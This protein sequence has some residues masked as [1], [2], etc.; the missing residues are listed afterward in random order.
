MMKLANLTAA[1]A[2]A[3]ALVAAPAAQASDQSELVDQAAKTAHHMKTDPAFAQAADTFHHAKAVMI[4]PGLLKAGFVFGGEGGDGVLLERMGRHWSPPAFY[5]MA[6]ASFGFQAGI[7]KAELVLLIMSDRALRGIEQGEVKLGAGGGLTVVT[8]SGGAEAATP[9]NLA[10]DIVVWTSATGLYGG[11]T[12]NGSV[13]K[14]LNDWN[15]DFYGK[16]VT[17]RDILSGKVRS[18]AA[19][20]LQRE[21]ASIH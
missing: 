2:L 7:E 8:L 13:I 16:P 19:A 6:S 11:L 15:D 5:S 20:G 9:A 18:R 4:I 3:A 14:P 10:G 21:V 17:L 1:A 12:L